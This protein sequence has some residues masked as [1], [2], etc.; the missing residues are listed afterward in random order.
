MK[1]MTC[2]CLAI[3]ATSSNGSFFPAIRFPRQIFQPS[4]RSCEVGGEDADV[5]GAQQNPRGSAHGAHIQEAGVR[6]DLPAAHA[7]PRVIVVVAQYPLDRD[8]SRH[9]NALRGD[10]GTFVPPDSEDSPPPIR[11]PL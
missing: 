3:K 4:L 5:R 2:R 11:G 7:L 8:P 10:A 6:L 1:P 9:W